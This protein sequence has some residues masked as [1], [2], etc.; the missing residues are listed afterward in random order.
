MNEM[1]IID[2]DCKCGQALARYKKAKRGA[3]Q[4]MYLDMILEDKAGVFSGKIQT[5]E[6]IFC[7]SCKKRVAT[8]HMIHGRPAAKVNHGAVKSIRT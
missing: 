4:K 7:P 5:G 3:L 6:N 1:R 2:V 8:V